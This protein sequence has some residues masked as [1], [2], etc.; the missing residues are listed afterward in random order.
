MVRVSELLPLILNNFLF[1]D[2][3]YFSFSEI[4]YKEYILKA[5]IVSIIIKAVKEIAA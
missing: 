2:G 5:L 4:Q 1:L 3:L